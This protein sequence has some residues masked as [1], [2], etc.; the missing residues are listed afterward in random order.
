MKIRKRNRIVLFFWL[1]FWTLMAGVC[2]LM[3]WATGILHF[4][5]L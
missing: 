5:G 3:G 1:P 2:A 4:A